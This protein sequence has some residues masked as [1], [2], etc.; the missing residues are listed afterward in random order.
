MKLS[1]PHEQMDGLMRLLHA[2]TVPS[3]LCLLT[4][5]GWIVEIPDPAPKIDL[6]AYR[7]LPAAPSSR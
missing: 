5:P 6:S 4:G 1:I 2:A 7:A 3:V